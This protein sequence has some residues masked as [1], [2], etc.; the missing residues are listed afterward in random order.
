MLRQR[1]VKTA[2]H[3]HLTDRPSARPAAIEA[4]ERLFPHLVRWI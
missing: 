3:P 2:S 4:G 1:D